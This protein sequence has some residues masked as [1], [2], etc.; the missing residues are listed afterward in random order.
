ML[1]EI[2]TSL[3]EIVLDYVKHRLFP[4]TVIVFVLFG[5]LVHRLFVLQIVE[6]EEHEDSFKYKSEKTLTIDSVRGNIFD[7]NGKLLA[8][9]ELS[10]SVVYG[11]DPNISS[12]AEEKGMTVNELKNSVVYKTIKILEEN[13][14]ELSIDIPIE[15]TKSG[16]LKFKVSGNQLKLFLKDAYSAINFDDLSDSQKNS[17]A[18]DVFNYLCDELFEI[19]DT[20]NLQD[21]LNILG[22]R[23][24]LWLNRYQQYMPVT[25]AYDVSEESNAAITEYCDELYGVEVS[26]K[27][28]RKYNYAE[29]FAHIIGYIGEVST[30]EMEE[31]N[32]SLPE[33]SQ[34]VAGEMIG[35]A[36]IEQYSE[37]Y[38]R[39]ESGYETMYVDNLG[40][41]IEMVESKPA[42]A[43]NDVYL[44]IDADLQKYCY[45]TLEKEI[46]SIILAKLVNMSSVEP[47]ENADIPITDV[48]FG[49]FDNSIL[50]I[51]DMGAEDATEHEKR[52]FDAFYD[53]KQATLDDI[54]R[55]LTVS[56]TPL[57]DLSVTYQNY[58]EYICEILSANDIFNVDLVPQDEAPFQNYINNQTSLYE[59]LKYAISIEAIDISG[60]NAESN[61]Y[62]N[63]EIYDLLCDYIVK[64]LSLDTNF[65]KLIVE[66]MIDSYEI[67]GYDVVELL[68]E[69]EVLD[70]EG[71]AE[72]RDFK[73]GIYGPFE[74][75]QR[76]I[77]NLEITPAMLALDPCSGAVIV[78]DVNTG[79]VLALVSYP[80]YDNNKLTNEIDED[81]Y[82][83]LMKD[84]TSPMY[85]RATQQQTAPGSTFKVISAVTGL[86]E[87][88]ITDYTSVT[89]TGTFDKIEPEAH[90]WIYP[91]A[92]GTLQVPEAIQRSCNMFFYQVGYSLSMDETNEYNDSYG[93]SRLQKYAEMFGLN[94]LSGVELPEVKP[95]ISDKDAVRSSIGQGTNLFAPV[96]LSRYV[97]TV[98]NR[99]TCYNLT[100][101]D[102]VTDL[103]NE[104]IMD[105]EATVHN[106]V[107]I[108]VSTWN[109]VQDGMRRVITNA[110]SDS[111]LINRINV[112]V[113]GKSGTAQESKY[114]PD[115]AVYISYAPYENP[116]VSV[117]CV[118]Q[119]GY[120]SGNVMEL[121][122][123]IYAYLYDPEKLI[124]AEMSGNTLISD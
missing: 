73:A 29:C 49:L 41:V 56:H 63:D 19:S 103:N 105:N 81:Y 14:D 110:V 2:L 117:T 4:V 27:S 101:I 20:Y 74:F 7:R 30:D 31:R 65:D 22:V 58:M 75:M 86:T 39:G 32:A 119:N 25:I 96:Q 51:D 123:F 98:A 62:D 78:T 44:T 42:T 77:K 9:N 90:C 11:N 50:S 3:K 72:Y 38:L 34:Y 88:V 60:F 40:K 71:D 76:K 13:G 47:G 106:T 23:Y 87:G 68:Y 124:G 102:K 111:A 118:I 52:L 108:D 104:V 84:K 36:G 122:G 33:D 120:S 109:T 17:T 8:Y 10:Y 67:T 57:Y 55:I 114:R 1:K 83:R 89:C 59:F 54:N 43:G 12:Y 18:E 6:G 16:K 45:D 121:S 92:H 115:H 15:L 94:D 82:N 99:G 35:K 97:T 85:N 93:L 53:K 100:L 116:E 28:L 113:A 64:Y 46:A 26:V 69:Q 107:D 24:K 37:E 66:D 70:A 80:G 91:E 61:Y 112:N 5:I 95:H 79:D 21:R 48:Y